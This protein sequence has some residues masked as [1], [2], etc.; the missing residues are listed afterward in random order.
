[1]VKRKEIAPASEK[2]LSINGAPHLNRFRIQK[3]DSVG[4]RLF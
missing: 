2:E 3:D 1:M 4:Y